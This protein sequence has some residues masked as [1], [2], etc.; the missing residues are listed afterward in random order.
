[1]KVMIFLQTIYSLETIKV[2]KRCEPEKIVSKKYL[3]MLG[4]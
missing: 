3:Q 4:M 1:M 2:N